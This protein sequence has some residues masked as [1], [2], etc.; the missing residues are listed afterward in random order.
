MPGGRIDSGRPAVSFASICHRRKCALT[1]RASARSGVTS[2]AVLPGSSIAPRS[3]SAIACASSAGVASSTAATPVRRRSSAFSSVH[4]PV[5]AAGAKAL[6][7][8]RPRNAPAS[9]PALP[10][11]CATSPRPTPMR[12][13]IS[14]RWNCGC[15]SIDRRMRPVTGSGACGPSASHSASGIWRSSPA[16]TVSP[17]GASATQRSSRATAG[18]GSVTP[19]AQTKP[20]GGRVRQRVTNRSSNI[21]RRVAASIRP[22]RASSP[23]QR[24]STIRKV[25]SARCQ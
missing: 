20:A 1:R 11:Q 5:K 16:N 21:R 3:A 2:A 9:G 25:E 6:A 22:S 4:L 19:A 23:G 7:I 14:F 12:S 18:A 13:R 17:C 24:S 15:V 8:A 10:G